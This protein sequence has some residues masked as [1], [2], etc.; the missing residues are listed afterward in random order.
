MQ[1]IYHNNQWIDASD[2]FHNYS[3]HILKPKYKSGYYLN[4]KS[5]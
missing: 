5:A 4:K 1:S 3:L 2:N